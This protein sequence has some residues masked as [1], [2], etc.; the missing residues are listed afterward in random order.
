MANLDAYSS[1]GGMHGS[2]SHPAHSPIGQC[3]SCGTSLGT[4]K[5]APITATDC[6]HWCKQGTAVGPIET[7][8]VK[9]RLY[10]DFLWVIYHEHPPIVQYPGT[11]WLKFSH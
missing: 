8:R 10:V 5:V 6:K 2:S 3:V 7:E 11:V 1:R 9:G 4:Y